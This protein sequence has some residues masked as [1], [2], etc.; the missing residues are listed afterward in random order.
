MVR[1][2]FGEGKASA[3]EN[4]TT[5]PAATFAAMSRAVSCAARRIVSTGW[6]PQAR[7][8]SRSRQAAPML[9]DHETMARPFSPA[10][11]ARA[12][13]PISRLATAIVAGAVLAIVHVRFRSRR[14]LCP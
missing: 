1:R 12:L 14:A 4:T 13:R 6:P 7:R 10:S 9:M 3:L 2:A 5:T 11:H 8:R